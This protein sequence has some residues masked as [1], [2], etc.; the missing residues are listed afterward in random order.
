MMMDRSWQKFEDGVEVDS[1]FHEVT[2]EEVRR[3]RDAALLECDWRGLKDVVLS[4]AWK[5][6]RQALRDL[7]G[8]DT[9]DEAADNWPVAPDD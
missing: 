8:F 6:Y 7:G 5:E 4:T 2:W 3:T 9:A 1:G